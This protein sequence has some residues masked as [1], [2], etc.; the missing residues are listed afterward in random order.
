MDTKQ[1]AKLRSMANTLEPIV[2]V[3]KEGVSEAVLAEADTAL[4]AHE[5]IKGSVGKGL[6]LD[7][8]E[9]L[10][11]LCLKLEAEPVQV[12]GRKFVLYRRSKKKPVIEL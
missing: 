4:E 9:T 10:Q 1:R 12:I 2:Y 6:D 5:L 7:A 3:G 11:E 8:R